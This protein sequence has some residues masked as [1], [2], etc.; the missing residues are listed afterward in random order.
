MTDANTPMDDVTTE[1]K[2]AVR[3][4]AITGGFSRNADLI[5]YRFVEG[6]FRD[7][8]RVHFHIS[9]DWYQVADLGD[10]LRFFIWHGNNVKGYAGFPFYGFAKKVTGSPVV[11]L[12]G[13]R[14]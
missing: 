8:P 5:S 9:E 14:Q 1:S 11:E 13:Q 12:G 10:K 6:M 7:E 2:R 4:E 3:R